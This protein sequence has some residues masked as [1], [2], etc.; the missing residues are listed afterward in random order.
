[1]EDF[2]FLKVDRRQLLLLYNCDL[3]SYEQQTS[4]QRTCN[5]HTS[6]QSTSEAPLVSAPTDTRAIKHELLDLLASHS[7]GSALYYSRSRSQPSLLCRVSIATC[8]L[9]DES[10]LSLH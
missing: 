5:L 9:Y 2:F 1:M 8:M 4:G 3:V 6:H 7:N 10:T